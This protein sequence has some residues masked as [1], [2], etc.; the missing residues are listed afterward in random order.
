MTAKERKEIAERLTQSATR[1]K[2]FKCDHIDRDL[3][4]IRFACIKDRRIHLMIS[5]LAEFL[6]TGRTLEND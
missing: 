6:R 1:A 5:N 3:D 2:D 4:I